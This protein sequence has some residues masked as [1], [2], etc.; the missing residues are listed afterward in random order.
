MSLDSVGGL[1]LVQTA[2]STLLAGSWPGLD[3]EPARHAR[4]SAPLDTATAAGHLA[5][6]DREHAPGS[7]ISRMTLRSLRG[8]RRAF[9]AFV[10]GGVSIGRRSAPA[11]RR[12]SSRP[13]CETAGV[14]FLRSSP[15]LPPRTS[16]TT[17][18][19]GENAGM[20]DELYAVGWRVPGRAPRWVWAVFP[21]L[22]DE[23]RVARGNARLD[24]GGRWRVYGTRLV[25]AAGSVREVRDRVLA[26]GVEE[27]ARRAR[28][29]DG[30]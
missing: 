12:A 1:V 11:V 21:S 13:C 27:T 23:V 3:L 19:A 9:V 25:E 6:T 16:T 15:M 4:P 20:T 10:Y 14:S 26:E 29:P 8:P 7:P 2:P 5:P 28:R 30:R 24:G 22:A 18:A 17:A